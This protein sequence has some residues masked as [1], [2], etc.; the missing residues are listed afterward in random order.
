M[1]TCPTCQH[2]WTTTRKPKPPTRSP[3]YSEYSFDEFGAARYNR[4]VRPMDRWD[5]ILGVYTSEDSRE[6]RRGNAARSVM[7]PETQD[8]IAHVIYAAR[9]REVV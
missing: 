8:G 1:P 6:L 5:T 2:H 3:A 9:Q 7:L 4:W